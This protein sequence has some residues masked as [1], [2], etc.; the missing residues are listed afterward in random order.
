MKIINDFELIEDLE[1]IPLKQDKIN[2]S[3]EL[4]QDQLSNTI[5]PTIMRIEFCQEHII[6]EIKEIKSKVNSIEERNIRQDV[7]IKTILTL[8]KRSPYIIFVIALLTMMITD[9]NFRISDWF[10]K[11]MKHVIDVKN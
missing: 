7:H 3:L 4:F 1:E 10:S 5:I 9:H 6:Q 8:V 2:S 11:E